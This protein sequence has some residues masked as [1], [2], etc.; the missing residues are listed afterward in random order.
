M[1]ESSNRIHRHVKHAQ[2]L[3]DKLVE[4]E[5]VSAPIA[6]R[7]VMTTIQSASVQGLSIYD[8]EAFLF[9]AR[10]V[11]RA[12]EELARRAAPRGKV[13]RPWR[14]RRLESEQDG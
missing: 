13:A 1:Q 11:V 9:R 12:I 6:R 4:R 7:A 14:P 2:Q 8:T 10:Q 5:G 3:V